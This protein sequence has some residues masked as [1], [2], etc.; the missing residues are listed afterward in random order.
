VTTIGIVSPGAMG[1][2][3]GRAWAAGGA[4]VVATVNGRS[5]RTR[6]LAHG[7]ELLP[8][9]AEVVRASDLVLSVCPPGAAAEV[10]D[11]V[12][13]AAS[14]T[15]PVYADLNAISPAL[16]ESL[17]DSAAARGLPFVDGSISGGPPTP[18]GDTLVYLS[19]SH[20]AWLAGLAA[21]GIRPRVVGERPGTASAVKM[22]TASVYKGTTLV[23]L[24]AL[25]T[26]HRLGVLDHVL[27][28]LGEEFPDEVA[29]AARRLAMAASKSGRFV[30]EMDQIA[31]TQG[32]AGVGSTLFAG[33]SAAYE[34]VSRTPLGDLTPEEAR[35]IDDLSDVLRR[36]G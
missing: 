25:E 2:A 9:L 5:E 36:L 22:C 19:G 18:G 32:A 6:R 17:A 13:A 15:T 1:S 23:W 29:G 28:D 34:R 10:L 31:A 27:A 35:R 20:A 12:L 14:G 7:L 11:D 21:D 26:A 30:G 16:A 24:Q 33:M 8:T 4:R 3:L